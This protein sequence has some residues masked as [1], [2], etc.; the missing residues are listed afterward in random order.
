M[1]EDA[2]SDTTVTRPDGGHPRPG[3]PGRGSHF[4]TRPAEAR[5]RPLP[6]WRRLPRRPLPPWSLRRLDEVGALAQVETISS[7]SGGSIT[8]AFLAD[9][10]AGRFGAGGVP[11]GTTGSL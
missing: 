8:A 6:V 11:T 5:P 7:V 2:G 3:R 1:R 10:I 4:R 9:R